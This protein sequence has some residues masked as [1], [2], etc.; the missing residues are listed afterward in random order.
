[1]GGDNAPEIVVE[2]AFQSKV[3]HPNLIFSFFGDKSKLLPL[4]DNR[5]IL[6]DSNIVHTKDHKSL[7]C[8]IE[9]YNKTVFARFSTHSSRLETF[10]R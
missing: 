6:N 4:I 7:K 10:D 5:E 1:M 8:N 3:R 9:S 2:G